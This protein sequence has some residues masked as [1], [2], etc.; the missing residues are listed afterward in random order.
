MD[1]RLSIV[2]G[3][4]HVDDVTFSPLRLVAVRQLVARARRVGGDDVIVCLVAL[5]LSWWRLTLNGL[6][7]S[8]YTAA[9]ITGA[10][11]LRSLFFASFDPAGVMAIDK[12]PLGLLAPA[13]AIHWFGVSSWTVLAPQGAMFAAGALV[14]HQAFRR[15]FHLHAARLATAVV[16]LTP[17]DA[18]V[19]R[20]NNPDELLVLITI[21]GLVLLVESIRHD[22]LG[23][24]VG[25]GLC[26][27]LAFTTKQL[28]AVVGVPTAL[29]ALVALSKGGCGRRLARTAAYAIVAVT[30]SLAWI[31]AVDNVP[32]NV[33][34]Y[35]SNSANNT[36]FSLAFGF[37]G[38]HRVRQFR[39]AP[40]WVPHQ[41]GWA[42]GIGRLLARFLPQRNLFGASYL[43]QTSWLL[44]PALLG[45]VLVIATRRSR[46]RRITLLL[47]GW[48][49][50]QS[51]VFAYLP[52]KFSPYYLAPL[53]PGVA[54]LIAA[55]V[56]TFVFTGH[57]A[58]RDSLRRSDT[59]ALGIVVSALAIT[60]VLATQ[61]WW[62]WTGGL[63]VALA[64]VTISA[65]MSVHVAPRFARRVC[66]SADTTRWSGRVLR[67]VA[68][69]ASVM[70]VFGVPARWTFAELNH[71]Q[72]PIAPEPSLDTPAGPT[73]QL[74]TVAE[75]DTH[76][77][78]WVMRHNRGDALTLATPRI[79]D[80]AQLV[81]D[82]TRP[83]PLG[84]FFGTDAYPLIG[85]FTG[86]IKNHHLRWV[87][88]PELPPGR[89][90]STVP[91]ASIAKPWGPWVRAHCTSTPNT[92][93]GGTDPATYWDRYRHAPF[94]APLAL[95]DCQHP[96]TGGRP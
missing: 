64:V 73:A 38:T 35:V 19:A 15:W 92:V 52:G 24:V 57:G 32:A 27:G 12:P 44:V 76:L 53:I 60:G 77:L 47:L 71:R 9:A 78:S 29:V 34:P 75:N 85:T 58:D 63:P 68:L 17:I 31:V 18:A 42:T 25:A 40:S 82:G 1:S 95:Y 96:T 36:E 55:I 46:T 22:H 14:A 56:D 20:N 16:L 2:T 37:N 33:R 48:T 30:S 62:S 49:A 87:A 3:V 80:S 4:P 59:A 21:I 5:L 88:L 72:D 13:L 54:A 39:H 8:Y 41:G 89:A 93:W 69:G 65:S 11:S 10:H 66:P 74:Q 6:G 23:W 84:G 43:T 90:L 70:L 67:T 94:H 45:A 51:I 61:R 81:L 86:W 79:I 50:S 7:N 91:P 28:Q 83:V 26:V